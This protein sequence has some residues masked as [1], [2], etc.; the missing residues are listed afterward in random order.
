MG[1]AV[2]VVGTMLVG[3]AL[4]FSAAAGPASARTDVEEAWVKN[5]SS[6][7]NP[8]FAY[9]RAVAVDAA[10]DVYVTGS[11]LGPNGLPD[12]VTIKYSAMGQ[13]L[14]VQR[15][16]GPAHDRDAATSLALDAAGN[17][18]VTGE[19]YGEGFS[20]YLTIKYSPSGER[21]WVARYDGPA[22]TDDSPASVATDGSGSVY[23]TGQS[24]GDGTFYDYAT[25]KYSPSGDEE[26]V[27]RYD[28]R[29][30]G[31]DIAA[32]IAVDAASN[33]YVTGASGEG[34]QNLS[35][36][37]TIKYDAAGV[38]QW[39]GRY[40]NSYDYATALAVDGSGAVYVTG[41]SFGDGT[42]YDYATVK[43]DPAGAERW[44]ARYD[45]GVGDDVAHAIAVDGAGNVS[46]TG[47]SA[48]EG[49]AYDFATIQY[50]SRGRQKWVARHDG[51][52][53]GNDKAM[54]LALTATGD[55]VV[56][57]EI[58]IEFSGPDILTIDYSDQGIKQWQ[59]RFGGPN[60]KDDHA[61]AVVV[62]P[63]GDVV[64]TGWSEPYNGSVFTTIK[65]VQS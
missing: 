33:V 14:W 21:T 45:G 23:V 13:E 48:G 35:D 38:E 18:Y 25:I 34:T 52:W 42:F 46:V 36:Y 1:A 19:T 44:V 58:W 11:S 31:D 16:D 4:L 27:A 63:A 64:V 2:K 6:G 53:H 56:T 30:H 32:D 60:D 51:P 29:G 9:S 55:V 65:Y 20:D 43:Y 39:V 8:E 12:F 49:T 28:G 15:F 26:W 17:V 47:E 37:L 61:A 57:G 3:V 7:T 24:T 50:T 59:A 40:A 5:Y 22:G 10:G 62:D 54:A 41:R